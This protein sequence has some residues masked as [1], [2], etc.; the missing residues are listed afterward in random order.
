MFLYRSCNGFPTGREA[1]TVVMIQQKNC[2]TFLTQTQRRMDR[3][4]NGIVSGKCWFELTTPAKVSE[5]QPQYFQPP[6]GNSPCKITES[7]PDTDPMIECSYS[8]TDYCPFRLLMNYMQ[9]WVCCML[10]Q[11]S[12]RRQSEKKRAGEL[13][14]STKSSFIFVLQHK[15]IQEIR[16][17][18]MHIEVCSGR[19]IRP[20]S[21]IFSFNNAYYLDMALPEEYLCQLIQ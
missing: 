19:K 6:S 8:Q 3:C 18:Y 10:W 2:K 15:T 14:Q 16:N 5:K 17:S 21:G 7:F 12:W 4:I 11:I 1:V 20:E 9:K 13:W